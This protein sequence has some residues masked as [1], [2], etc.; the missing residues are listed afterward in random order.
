[1]HQTQSLRVLFKGS[2]KLVRRAG[3]GRGYLK[4]V[5]YLKDVIVVI[6]NNN[7][8]LKVELKVALRQT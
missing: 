7:H 4:S 6:N 5:D 3:V 1:M 2:F 8:L